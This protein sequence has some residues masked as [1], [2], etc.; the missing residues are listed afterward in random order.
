MCL[1]I[2]NVMLKGLCTVHVSLKLCVCGSGLSSRNSHYLV[3]VLFLFKFVF[4]S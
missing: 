2:F 4:A 1:L 3:F